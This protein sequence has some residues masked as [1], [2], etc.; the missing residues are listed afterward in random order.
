MLPTG[1]DDWSEVLSRTPEILNKK[2]VKVWF[3]IALCPVRWTA[4]STSYLYTVYCALIVPDF[5]YNILLWGFN[6][7]GI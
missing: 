1:C 6:S 7:N 5:N 2:K 3:Y 4:Q